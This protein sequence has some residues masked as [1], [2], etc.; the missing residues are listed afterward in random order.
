MNVPLPPPGG[1][2]D[3]CGIGN[4][5]VVKIAEGDHVV[6]NARVIPFCRTLAISNRSL[7]VLELNRGVLFTEER[8]AIFGVPQL[9]QRQPLPTPR[10][11]ALGLPKE[12]ARC[13]AAA[14]TPPGH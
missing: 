9:F 4:P 12:S 6:L 3:N 1:E 11:R 14:A 10:L 13:S 2:D 8:Q 5:V 7:A